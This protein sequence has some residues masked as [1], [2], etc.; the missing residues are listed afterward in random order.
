M[1]RGPEPEREILRRVAPLAVPAVGAAL[2]VGAAA[3]GWPTGWSASLGVAIVALNAAASG[4]SQA[5]AAGVSLTALA[6]VTMVGF[7]VRL[8]LIVLAMALLNRLSWFSALAF[9]LA[10]VPAT[11][12]LLAY[13]MRRVARGVG[14][15]LTL[16]PER[17][18]D[19]A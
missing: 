8:G 3:G 10:V 18:R 15:E 17:R 7:V 13:E 16:P 11:V 9:G 4:L 12:G 14:Q 5:W 6:A 19:P 2:V 1:N